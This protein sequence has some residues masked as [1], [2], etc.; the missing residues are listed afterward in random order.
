MR[1]PFSTPGTRR[2][3]VHHRQQLKSLITPGQWLLSTGNKQLEPEAID[4]KNQIKAGPGH[5]KFR[6]LSNEATL[7]KLHQLLYPAKMK[8]NN[9]LKHIEKQVIMPSIRQLDTSTRFHPSHTF[10]EFLKGNMTKIL[11]N[12][13]NS[14]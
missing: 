11:F 6:V 7:S 5:C 3:F 10:H 2:S 1:T 12:K 4:L 9:Y 13:S 8:L 14:L